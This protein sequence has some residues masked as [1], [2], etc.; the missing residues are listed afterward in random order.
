MLNFFLKIIDA[1][2]TLKIPYMLSGS[3][4]MGIYTLPRATRDFDFV[5]HLQLSDVEKFTAYFKDGYYCDTDAVKEAIAH[6]SI[7]NV[8]DHA[9][10]YKADFVILK[11]E[12]FRQLEFTR[13]KEIEYLD[14]KIFVVSAEDLLLSKLIWIQ[15]YQSAVQSEDIKSILSSG[16]LDLDYIREWIDKLDLKTFD[17]I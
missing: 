13:R 8:I 1:L 6:H 9:S 11:N 15:D 14:K 4:A 12:P 10:G 16:N 5:V 2:N 17:L 7:F 3:V